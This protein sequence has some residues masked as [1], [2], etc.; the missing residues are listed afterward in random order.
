MFKFNKADRNALMKELAVLEKGLTEDLKAIEKVSSKLT[1]EQR[2]KVAK[3]VA[4]SKVLKKMAK[5]IGPLAAVVPGLQPVA[6]GMA[7]ATAA[8]GM[9]AT[10]KA[11]KARAAVKP[12]DTE[13]MRN[14]PFNRDQ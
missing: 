8:A 3:K 12:N 7:A 1:P 9:A 4:H 13:A 10:T 11:N 5:V 6:A 2:K 14:D